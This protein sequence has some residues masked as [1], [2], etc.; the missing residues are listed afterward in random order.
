MKVE[1]HGRQL[2]RIGEEAD[3]IIPIIRLHIRIRCTGRLHIMVLLQTIHILLHRHITVR[4]KIAIQ[5]CMVAT[6]R[7]IRLIIIEALLR[8]CQDLIT[9]VCQCIP[10]I[11]Q[12]HHRPWGVGCGWRELPSEQDIPGGLCG[13]KY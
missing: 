5:P 1:P 13:P 7:L 4:T 6:H 12:D 11:W 10:I 2:E 8:L 9:L 3:G